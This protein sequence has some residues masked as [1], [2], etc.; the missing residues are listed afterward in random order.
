MFVLIKEFIRKNK[1]QTISIIGLVVIIIIVIISL[2]NP[3]IK[4]EEVHEHA[5]ATRH[6]QTHTNEH[7]R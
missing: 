7:N 6:Q 4:K 2:N 5:N 3:T 1:K